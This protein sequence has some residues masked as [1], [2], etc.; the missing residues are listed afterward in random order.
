METT[1]KKNQ[2]FVPKFYLKL[3]SFNS[4]EKEV[5][6]FNINH[7]LFK[8]R[9]PLK[10]QAKGDFFYGKDGKLEDWLSNLETLSAPIFQKII[11]S[12]SIDKINKDEGQLLIL[13]T[14]LLAYRT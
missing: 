11:K 4:N 7:T 5:G 2:H 8:E 6:L 12:N 10:K 1:E 3:F 9:V 14:L 13:F